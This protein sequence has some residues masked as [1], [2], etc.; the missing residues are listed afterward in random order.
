M[1]TTRNKFILSLV[2]C[3]VTVAVFSK[4]SRETW[5]FSMI[6]IVD[7]VLS[8]LSNNTLKVNMPVETTTEGSSRGREK[9]THLE[10][11][12]R[13][14]CGIAPWLELGADETKEG[15]L[16]KKYV[17]MTLAGL[18]NAVDSASPDFLSFTADRQNL[19]DAAFLAE[20]FLRAP[21]QLWKNLDEKSQL[22]LIQSFKATRQ[23]KPIE[24]NWLLFSAMIEAFLYRFTGECDFETIDYAL[25]KFELWY[26]GDGW[27][28]DGAKF[29]FD[30]YNS[31]VIHPMMYDVLASVQHVS[32]R[33]SALFATQTIRLSRHAEQLERLISPEG[34]YP[35]FGRSLV[36][37]FGSFHALSQ[38][39]LSKKLPAHISPAQVR[40]ALSAV[41]NRQI[42]QKGTFDK[43]GWLT[44]GFC[45]H[46]PDLAESYIS[47]GSLY[48]CATVFLPLGLPANDDFW[49][50]KPEE[51]TNKKAW[52]GEKI[53]I[54]KA[55]KN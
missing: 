10:A 44:L 35:A 18:K 17:E 14:V 16:R 2:F 6:K 53:K 26:K 7:P 25:D 43:S 54:D 48:L 19:V 55:L 29:H 37:R 36:Y 31:L 21:N 5:I 45:G 11:V 4:N 22:L 3:L 28:G 27:Y 42:N 1:A 33:Y 49:T 51:W 23:F 47:T 50:G 52:K 8:N 32:P 34:T 9:V 46:Q 38:A 41:I 39:V 12:G 20:G 15:K 30:Y 24:S 40:C 13:T